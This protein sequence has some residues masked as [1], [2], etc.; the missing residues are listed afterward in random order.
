MTIRPGLS[1]GVG[2]AGAIADN[3]YQMVQLDLP[4]TF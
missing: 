3:K 2:L 4:V 1:Y